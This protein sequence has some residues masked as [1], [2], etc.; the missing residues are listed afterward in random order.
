M[1]KVN[2]NVVIA[3]L[4][5]DCEKPLLNNIP[6]IE[7]LRARFVWSEVVVVEN[8]SKD[9]TKQILHD[10]QSRSENVSIISQDFGT[11]TIPHKSTGVTSPTTTTYRIEKMAFYR[12]IYLEHI[13]AIKKN[14]DYVIVIDVDI[15]NFDV[16]NLIYSIENAPNDWGGIFAN[17]VT[18]KKILGYTSKIYYDIFAIYQ[19]P[20]VQNFSYTEDSLHQ[21]FKDINKKVNKCEYFDIISAFGG[22]GIYKYDAIKSLNYV[23]VNNMNSNDEAICEHIPF[24]EEIVNKSYKNYIARNLTVTYGTHNIGLIAKLYL[25][26]YFLSFLARNK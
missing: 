2:K 17:G 8:D 21:T 23:V 6:L 15:E 9:K 14:I 24:N 19:Y 12:N 1:I 11:L 26:Y 7:E 4:A 18:R 16:E 22:I 5:R 13:K 20:K 10:W 3:A 25:P